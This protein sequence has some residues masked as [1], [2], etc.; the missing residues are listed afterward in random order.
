VEAR[1]VV[2]AE[3]VGLAEVRELGGELARRLDELVVVTGSV[4]LEPVAVLSLPLRIRT[5]RDALHGLR[6]YSRSC[7]D[8]IP[9]HAGELRRDLREHGRMGDEEREEWA[10]AGSVPGEG[11]HAFPIY[12]REDGET[13]IGACSNCGRTVHE[14]LVG[15]NAMAPCEP[16]S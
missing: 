1:V 6:A 4:R 15:P 13:R 2:W 9:T 11:G 7:T 3:Q 16:D 12:R 14:V 8:A 5:H 10:H